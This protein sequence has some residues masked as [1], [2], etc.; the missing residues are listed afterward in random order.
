MAPSSSIAVL[1]GKVE[2][3]RWLCIKRTPHPKA[4]P[5]RLKAETVSLTGPY[6]SCV[7]PPC[8]SPILCRWA[9]DLRSVGTRNQGLREQD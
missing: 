7:I 2:R 1:P 5:S 4:R 9:K 8:V 6:P 3:G